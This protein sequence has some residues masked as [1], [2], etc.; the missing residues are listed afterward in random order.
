MIHD[1]TK[2]YLWVIGLCDNGKI[3]FKHLNKYK[4]VTN[5]KLHIQH[6]EL[7]YKHFWLICFRVN[8]MINVGCP[9]L[10]YV[11]SA[12]NLH[13]TLSV[14]RCYICRFNGQWF[15]GYFHLIC[16]VIKFSEKS[17]RKKITG[18]YCTK[19]TSCVF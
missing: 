8:K 14:S 1:R 18:L 12:G 9:Y 13:N 2:S 16:V 10:H 11:L 19:N 6:V 3:N 15:P 4:K 5:S 7:S 17:S